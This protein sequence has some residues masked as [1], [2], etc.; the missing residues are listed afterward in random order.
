MMKS[1]A[2]IFP[3]NPPIKS[4]HTLRVL[5]LLTEIIKFAHLLAKNSFRESK[6]F[7]EAECFAIATNKFTVKPNSQVLSQIFNRSV[8]PEKEPY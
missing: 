1:L 3:D 6:V 8:K 4:F 2:I 5:V 7:L